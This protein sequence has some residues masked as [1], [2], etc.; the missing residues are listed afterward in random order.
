MTDRK[1]NPTTKT[2]IFVKDA[3]GQDTQMRGLIWGNNAAWV[4]QCDELNGDITADGEGSDRV[5]ECSCK[6]QYEIVRTRNTKGGWNR[7]AAID[8][9]I[10]RE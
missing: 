2:S 1:P 9:R 5:I 8:I 7:G 10:V 3:D 4:C 6:R